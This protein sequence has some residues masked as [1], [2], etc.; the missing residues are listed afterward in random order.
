MKPGKKALSWANVTNILLG[1]E[2]E[3]SEAITQQSCNPVLLVRDVSFCYTGSI[4]TAVFW[5]PGGSVFRAHSKEEGPLV[6]KRGLIPIF[7][8]N[9]PRVK[10]H[11]DPAEWM[12]LFA[13]ENTDSHRK[14][15]PRS[16]QPFQ[17]T[18]RAQFEPGPARR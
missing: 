14:T 13:E 8:T 3:C 7:Q 10:K 4:P 2:E 12:H 16:T 1:G 11:R 6:A 17:L 15:G 5:L 9:P 18:P